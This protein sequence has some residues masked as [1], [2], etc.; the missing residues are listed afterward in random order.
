[1][2]KATREW[3]VSAE[4]DLLLIQEISQNADLTHLSA[5]HA[6]QAVEKSFKAVIEEYDLVFLKTHSLE[7]LY[8]TVRV[9]I[10]FVMNT[11]LLIVLDQIYIDAGYPGEMGL[12]P[13]GKPSVPEAIS[14]YNFANEIYEA[15][16]LS[17]ERSNSEIIDNG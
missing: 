12:L 10:S 7:T 4:S 1:M 14:F 5:F 16:K 13:D 17:C 8:N 3:F 15:A 2:K 11:E 6:Q 9:K